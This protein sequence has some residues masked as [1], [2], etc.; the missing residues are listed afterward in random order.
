MNRLWVCR[1]TAEN[2][3]RAEK[4]EYFKA[5]EKYCLVITDK[6]P[7]KM[8]E[9]NEEAAKSLTMQDW[10]WINSVGEKLKAEAEYAAFQRR[11]KE[12]INRFEAELIRQKEGLTDAGNPDG[13]RTE[14]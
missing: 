8:A 10:V 4:F 7:E 13:G 3:E 12:F 5:N 6:T 11:Q 9:V 14:E 2:I 1:T